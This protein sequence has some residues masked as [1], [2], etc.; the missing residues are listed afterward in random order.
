VSIGVDGTSPGSCPMADFGISGVVTA[1][2]LPNIIL[3]G[4]LHVR[5][6]SEQQF[7]RYCG[8]HNVS[9]FSNTHISLP[10]HAHVSQGNI[11]FHHET[12]SSCYI[13]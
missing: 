4:S 3:Q 12:M 8:T 11:F 6:Y 7:C 10:F 13:T 9:I 2:L 1:V 5:S